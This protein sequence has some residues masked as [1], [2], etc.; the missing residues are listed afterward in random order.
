MSVTD[1]NNFSYVKLQVSRD[2]VLP[3]KYCVLDMCAYWEYIVFIP[4]Y[5]IQKVMKYVITKQGQRRNLKE[6]QQIPNNTLFAEATTV[7]QSPMNTRS[8]IERI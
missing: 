3:Q 2:K 7:Y 5:T 4:P 6:H 8:T 1:L